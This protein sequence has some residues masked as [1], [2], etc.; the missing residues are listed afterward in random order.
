V[1]TIREDEI[2]RA[3]SMHG[4]VEKII[5]HFVGKPRDHLED[6]SIDGHII[7]K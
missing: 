7:L 3:C 2:D 1:I 5:Q 6:P 4:Q